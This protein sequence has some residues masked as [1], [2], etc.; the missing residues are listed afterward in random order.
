MIYFVLV[1]KKILNFQHQD[2][3]TIIQAEQE[4]NNNPY[5]TSNNSSSNGSD[6]KT[7]DLSSIVERLLRKQQKDHP[8]S[9]EN[10]KDASSHSMGM[11]SKTLKLERLSNVAVYQTLQ[12]DNENSD[13]KTEVRLRIIR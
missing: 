9:S 6:E 1:L 4:L 12:D 13:M 11:K 2:I 3:S 8:S 5:N 10:S 7:K